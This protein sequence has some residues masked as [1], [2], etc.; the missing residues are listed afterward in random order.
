MEVIHSLSEYP[1][2]PQPL[3]ALVVSKN[4][5]FPC[6]FVDASVPIL[7]PRSN[8]DGQSEQAHG[9]APALFRKG[10]AMKKFG[11][12]CLVIVG[13]VVVLGVVGALLARRA[14]LGRN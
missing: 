8:R 4:H 12:G 5:K 10:R 9:I 11:K 2:E 6:T 1:N 14:T 13:I 3:N 7:K